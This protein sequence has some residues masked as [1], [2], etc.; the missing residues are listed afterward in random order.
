MKTYKDLLLD[1]LSE[2][3]KVNPRWF[4]AVF[5]LDEHKMGFGP[6]LYEQI[7]D[8]EY[9]EGRVAFRREGQAYLTWVLQQDSS[10]IPQERVELN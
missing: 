5:E 3:M 10:A 7:S 1:G 8:E 6:K 2:A 4:R 9:R